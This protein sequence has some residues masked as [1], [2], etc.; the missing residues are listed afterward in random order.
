[1]YSN[2]EKVLKKYSKYKYTKPKIKYSTLCS[3]EGFQLTNVQKFL[4]EYI[5]TQKRILLYHGI[6]SGKTITIIHMC[7]NAGVYGKI[8]VVTQASLVQPFYD[9]L[10]KYDVATKRFKYVNK[11]IYNEMLEL[12]KTR[13]DRVL[14]RNE[15]IRL[16]RLKISIMINLVKKYWVFSYERFIKRRFHDLGDQN[17]LVI[18]EVQNLLNKSSQI[19]HKTINDFKRGLK[20]NEGKKV[21]IILSSA[22]PVYDNFKDFFTTINLLTFD[23]PF[24]YKIFI[25]PHKSEKEKKDHLK[26]LITFIN[27]HV[28]YYAPANSENIVYP[29]KY[30]ELVKCEMSDYQYNKYLEVGLMNRYDSLAAELS[31]QFY[32]GTRMI[33]NF[34][35]PDNFDDK[36]SKHIK[37]SFFE[38]YNLRKYSTKMY[39]LMKKLKTSEGKVIIYTNF[40]NN[41]GSNMIKQLLEF[42][43]Y[44]NY[45]DFYQDKEGFQHYKSYRVFAC[46]TGKETDTYRNLVKDYFNSEENKDGEKLKILILSPAGKEGLTLLG[47]REIHIMEPYWNKSR[48]E[49]IEGRGFRSCSHRYLPPKDRTIKTF[50]YLATFKLHVN[51]RMQEKI[52]KKYRSE[53]KKKES[54]KDTKRRRDSYEDIDDDGKMTNYI[55]YFISVD[56]YVYNMAE[57][58]EKSS[59]EFKDLLKYNSIDCELFKTANGLSKCRKK[60]IMLDSLKNYY[61]NYN[62]YDEKKTQRRAEKFKNLEIDTKI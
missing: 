4:G 6:G 15:K 2:Q 54:K 24:D 56:E 27:E 41:Y 55:K 14:T 39:T 61:S 45:F 5:K 19:Y 35:Y 46:F 49:Q 17:I 8:I 50:L 25:D 42:Y 23:D 28:S 44:T 53:D 51:K 33:S 7:E 47:V 18:D 3:I 37:F 59:K 21:G 16:K 22:T 10:V 60:K 38:A 20:W 31:N 48:I 40:T 11:K 13:M 36:R 57:E 29:K 9:E 43:G 32:S 62:Y 1:M 26:K 30:F 52:L 58:K 34:A 12:E